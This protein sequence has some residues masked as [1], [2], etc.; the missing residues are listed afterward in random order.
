MKIAIDKI[1]VKERIRKEILDIDKL[2][3]DIT[4]NGLLN[5]IT[6]MAVG[7]EYQ[8]LAGLRRLKAA[9]LLDWT[10][11]DAHEVTPIDAEAALRIEISENEQRME[12]NYSEKMDFARLLEEIERAKA[13]ERKRSGVKLSAADLTD[14]GAEGRKRETRS[15]VGEKIG[16]SGKQYDRAKYIA[17]HAPQEIIDELDRGERTIRGTYDE[18]RAA[19]KP[20][21]SESITFRNSGTETNPV[22]PTVTAKTEPQ[23]PAP[24]AVTAK[25]T[26]RDAQLPIS[27]QQVKPNARP[28]KVDPLNLLTEQERE[29]IRKNAEFEALP[30]QEKI[31]ELQRQLRAE[32]ARAAAA[33]SDLARERELRQNDVYHRDGTIELLKTQLEAANARIK[34]LEGNAHATT[35]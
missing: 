27:S 14:L 34:E 20:P 2:A 35:D 16:M 5:A 4:E 26:S 28:Q 31:A 9:Q 11:I 32:R 3:A 22:P 30:P 23:A 17:D 33:E 25:E 6:V 19:G 18:L 8:L 24:I 12:F 7:E 10:E 29:A 1:Q 15:I 21:K 13:S